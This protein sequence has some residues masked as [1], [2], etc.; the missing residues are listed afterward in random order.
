MY[1]WIY[2]SIFGMYGEVVG[3][4]PTRGELFSGK[5]HL[6]V[7]SW[8]IYIY[9]LYICIY[10]YVYIYMYIYIYTSLSNNFL[11]LF[12]M[13][14]HAYMYIRKHLSRNVGETHTDYIYICIYLHWYLYT[15]IY[16]YINKH[17]RIQSGLFK[18]FQITSKN[19]RS[20]HIY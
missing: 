4:S 18:G 3:S 6:G 11:G 8:H 2:I 14:V 1:A 5:F 19:G 20:C 9:I 16:V 17:M 13:S 7:Y 12:C 10:I 15:C